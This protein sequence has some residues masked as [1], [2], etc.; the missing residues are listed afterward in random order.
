MYTNKLHV[1]VQQNLT[2]T[3]L[4]VPSQLQQFPVSWFSVLLLSH[5]AQFA[6][7]DVM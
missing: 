6:I 5:F 1:I 4:P 2:S 7:D 3:S